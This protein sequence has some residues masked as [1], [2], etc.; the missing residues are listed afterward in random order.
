MA[1]KRSGKA[2]YWEHISVNEVDDDKAPVKIECNH[3][4]DEFSISNIARWAKEHFKDD[5]STCVRTSGKKSGKRAASSE[6]QASA[7]PSSKRHQPSPSLSSFLGVPKSVADAALDQL[8]M[9]FF[10]NPTVSLHL[11]ENQH[12]LNGLFMGLWLSVV[13]PLC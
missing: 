2:K 10:T 11:I 3:C 7:G 13:V 8:Y 6:D 1:A 9:F 4:E 5:F 12:L